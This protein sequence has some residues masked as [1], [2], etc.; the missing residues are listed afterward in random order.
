MIYV[1]PTPLHKI[2]RLIKDWDHY[3]G[4]KSYFC[5]DCD[6]GFDHDDFKH[7]PCVGKRCPSCKRKDCN[8]FLTAKQA[9]GPGNFPKPQEPCGICHRNFHGDNCYNY[10][11]EGK[12]IKTRSIRDTH[13]KCPDCRDVYELNSKVCRGVTLQQADTHKCGWEEC[14]IC[15]KKVELATHQYYIQRVPAVTFQERSH[16]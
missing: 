16:V 10:H 12:S 11:L 14:T 8:D 7:H 1:G 2:I 6:C 3:D 5:D 9:M 15:E 4:C 13:K